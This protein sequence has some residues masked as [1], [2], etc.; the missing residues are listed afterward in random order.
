MEM[1]EQQARQWLGD[2]ALETFR[3]INGQRNHLYVGVLEEVALAV[4]TE[5][6]SDPMRWAREL[7]LPPPRISLPPPSGS[8]AAQHVNVEKEWSDYR[9]ALE[10]L[11][12]E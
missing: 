6:L 8:F 12:D 10:V 3:R 9:I 7:G 1:T 11:A 2:Y 4:A 5:V